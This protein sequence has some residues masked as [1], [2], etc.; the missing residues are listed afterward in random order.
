MS[1][2]NPDDATI[3]ALLRRARTIAVV[4]ASPDPSRPSHEVMAY[5][6]RAG[7][8]TIPVR[9]DGQPV[10][11]EP[12]VP[13]LAAL[14]VAVDVV[15]VFR[16]PQHVAGVVDE[17]LALPEPRPALWLQDGVIDA[18]A[19]ARARAAGVTVV[20]DDC[21]LRAHARLVGGRP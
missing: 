2:Q 19:A 9:P 15:D 4:G 8:R 20:M 11:G 6:Q 14:P 18:A 16:R 1:W 12:S 7:Y 5:L 3:A 13:S 21:A 17:L 10:L